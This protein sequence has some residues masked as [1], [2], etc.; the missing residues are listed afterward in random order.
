MAVLLNGLYLHAQG[1]L[2]YMDTLQ[3][4]G[5]ATR[6]DTHQSI[7]AETSGNPI[8]K[9]IR[10]ADPAAE[11]WNDGRVW[12]YASHDQ[13]D[14]T[15]YSGM[16]G[17]HAFS[18][19]DL[20]HWTDH[21]E[22]LHSRDVGWGNPDG[23][24]MF[25]PDAAYKNDMYYLYF[26]HLSSEWRWRIGVATSQRPEG[27]FTDVGHYIEGT[28]NIDPTCFV[29]ED[30]Q[31][32]L[33]WGGGDVGSSVP[34]IARLKE[35]MTELAEEP[36]II[37]YGANNFGEGGYLH[38]R[39]S[40]YYFSYTCHSCWPYQAY[41]AI[42][43][44]P[45][46]PF[47]YKG[48]LNR[49]PPG[50]Q[51]HHSMIEFHNQWYYFYHTGNYEGGSLY[52]RNI[53]IDSLF[54]NADGTMQEIRQTTTGVGIDL[55]GST[56]GQVIPGSFE[57]EDYFRSEGVTR[58]TK[59]DSVTMVDQIG[60]GDWVDY[61]LDILGSETYSVRIQ[62][63]DVVAGTRIYLMVDEMLLDTV[64]LE[65]DTSL[66]SIPLFLYQ[67]KHTFKLQFDH[68]DPNTELLLV[69]WIELKGDMEYFYIEA[70]AKGGGAFQPE[71]ISYF[72]RGDTAVFIPTADFNHI[73]DSVWI[74]GMLQPISD[75]YTFHNITDNHVIEASFSPCDS[76][77]PT[78]Y[79]QVNDESLVEGTEVVITEGN[80][81]KL[82]VD[83]DTTA[84]LYWIGPHGYTVSDSMVVLENIKSSQQGI[85]TAILVNQQGCRT[86]QPF[87]VEVSYVELDVYEAE[88]FVEQ[89]GIGLESSTDIGGGKYVAYIENN[90]W[91]VYTLSLDQSGYYNII[92]RIAAGSDGGIIEISER[93]SLVAVVPVEGS[94][95]EGLDDWNTTLPVE[96]GFEEGFHVL[97]FIFKGGDGYLLNFNWFDLEF[98][99]EFMP[100][101]ATGAPV[102]MQTFPNPFVSSTRIVFTLD[103]PS[104]VDLS[105]YNSGGSLV[106]M[107]L[108]GEKL[109][110]GRHVVT[111][112]AAKNAQVLLEPGIYLIRLRCNR[113]VIHQKVLLMNR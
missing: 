93:D 113:Q 87:N 49:S 45:Y 4:P 67:G 31:A 68:P 106:S 95:S 25:A 60:Q 26:P 78:P 62:M 30:G 75:S 9:H 86:A 59:G 64:V 12:I 18:S 110:P 109:D 38:K 77:I 91:C 55:I 101:T 89:S 74:D 88:L 92:A 36:R 29:D 96:A 51:D 23:G 100:D 82:G 79:Y 103:Q 72:A 46:G 97:K 102:T 3:T 37:E 24:W 40:L 111:W 84:F 42:G 85:Y 8:I 6:L 19:Y 28:D 17:Y 71:G 69:D 94:L 80:T 7:Q 15:D 83:C 34:K 44:H 108:S 107:P 39:D 16:D 10:S 81:L 13:E 76:I 56:P 35:N 47:E 27:P 99:R 20:V 57:A 2:E 66:V 58:L 11:V 43:D 53:C 70:L 41:Y 73:L 52:R 32:Y 50:A 5:M 90:D 1:T 65:S 14:A 105:I 21:G 112:H 104:E 33:L 63:A 98:N 48:E 54:Y 61:V 22:V